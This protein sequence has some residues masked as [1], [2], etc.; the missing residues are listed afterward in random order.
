MYGVEVATYTRSVQKKKI[1]TL[2]RLAVTASYQK[3]RSL[4]PP[5]TEAARKQRKRYKGKGHR[6]LRRRS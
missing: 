5:T 3:E 1:E 4:T 2:R 6:N